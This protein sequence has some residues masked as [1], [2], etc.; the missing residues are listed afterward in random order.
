MTELYGTK[1]LSVSSVSGGD[2]H[3]VNDAELQFCCC[4]RPVRCLPC[5]KALC[6]HRQTGAFFREAEEKSYRVDWSVVASE[7]AVAGIESLGSC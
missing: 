4:Q 5:L 6:P 1:R 2:Y 7:A 3:G